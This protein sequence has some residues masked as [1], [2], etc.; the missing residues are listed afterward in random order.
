MGR[1][2][3]NQTYLIALAVVRVENAE[4]WGWFLHLVHG[5]LSLNEGN[6]ITIISDSHKGLFDAV[7]DWLPDPEHKKCTS[8]IYAN[9][10]KIVD[11]NIRDFLGSNI[12]YTR[13][14]V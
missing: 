8:H 10:K 4:N 12:F 1:D 11:Y 3:N 6:G 9:L 5:D 13:R 14:A 7:N 2:A